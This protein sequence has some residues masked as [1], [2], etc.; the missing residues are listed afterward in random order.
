MLMNSYLCLF[1]II[2]LVYIIPIRG[3]DGYDDKN[4]EQDKVAYGFQLGLII[5][6]IALLIFLIF[7]DL[8]L[9]IYNNIK[10]NNKEME[11]DEF[12][13]SERFELSEI[14]KYD[15]EDFGLWG[16]SFGYIFTMTI[17]I[18]MYYNKPVWI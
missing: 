6:G 16:N 15:L 7:F 18:F 5:T 14:F 12:T 13:R 4:D 8:I 1:F 17:L 9:I 10:N 11:E 2:P 3:V